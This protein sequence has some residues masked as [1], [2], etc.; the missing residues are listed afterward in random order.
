[1][2]RGEYWGEDGGFI[3]IRDRILENQQKPSFLKIAEVS[4]DEEGVNLS[5]KGG[6]KDKSARVHIF[7]FHFL[8]LDLDNLVAKLRGSQQE[9][10]SSTEFPFAMWK[11]FFL[12]N[13]ALGDEYRYVFDRKNLPRFVGNTLDKPKMLVKRNYIQDT[14]FAEE[15]I[16]QGARYESYQQA[17]PDMSSMNMIPQQRAIPMMK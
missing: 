2:H 7:A 5:L 15:R 4:A 1:M 16:S 8:P 3:R 12:S 9:S 13:R 14:T 6:A 11:N 10:F 17:M